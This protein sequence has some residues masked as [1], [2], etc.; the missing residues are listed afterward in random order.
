MK[1]K[2]L[3]KITISAISLAILSGC[4]NVEPRSLKDHPRASEES[5]KRALEE[6]AKWQK[7]PVLTE[8]VPYVVLTTPFAI[9]E[10]LKKQKI[11]LELEPE[12]SIKELIA[13]LGKLGISLI[14]SEKELQDKTV[15]LPNFN[16]TVG[17]LL[18]AVSRATDTW[19]T[20]HE[21]VI[22]VSSKEKI[23]ISIPQEMAFSKELSEGLKALGVEKQAINWIAGTAFLDISPNQF[24]K[25][26]TFLERFSANSAVVSIQ[27]AVVNVTL[28][29][30][31][32]Q[33]IDWE[34]LT[35]MSTAGANWKT[36]QDSANAF[37][38]G[39]SSTGSS[40][41]IQQPIINNPN[42][43][44]TIGGNTGSNTGSTTNTAQIEQSGIGGLLATG[45]SLSGVLLGNRF[46]FSGFFN[47]LQ[48]Y[49]VAETTQ[50]VML[51]TLAGNKVELESLTQVPYVSGVG[52][53]TT[54]STTVGSSSLGSSNTE[55]ANDG[56]TVEL[57]P[58]YNAAAD[59]VTIDLK[60]SI[61]SVISFKELSAGNQLGSF[62]QPIT[63][64]RSFNDYVKL[65]PGQ[66]A[67]VGGLTY[68]SIS[69][70]KNSPLFLSDSKLESQSL[71]VN[72][73][74]M[75][76]VLRPTVLRLGQILEEES[77]SSSKAE[78]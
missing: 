74:S 15:F 54:G 13:I 75:F 34:K 66:T 78:E 62:T 58:T 70:N 12:I 36:Y 30:S 45:G 73:Q 5:L 25:V 65:R 10:S 21:D 55:K 27:M 35:I 60:L 71:T 68:D 22:I 50:S 7:P 28:D 29:Q 69:N 20:W 41:V 23:G 6:D 48:T 56:I 57:T 8:G 40:G 2:N 31:V 52:V 64:K 39:G 4:A 44:S 51:K 76:I 63:G 33:G 11:T 18:S 32:K 59:T 26:K 19:F 53:T 9:P 14:I 72:R 46:A 67:I 1:L 61:E 77:G 38:S 37:R 47:F 42:N 3:S 43:G 17:S 16:G 24:R 49:G